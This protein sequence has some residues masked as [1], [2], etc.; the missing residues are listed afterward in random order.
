MKDARLTCP[1]CSGPI[2]LKEI[3]ATTKISECSIGAVCQPCARI[4]TAEQWRQIYGP[5]GRSGEGRG[6]TRVPSWD[7]DAMGAA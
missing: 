2:M 3:V 7:D 5:G 1:N 4:F 6:T